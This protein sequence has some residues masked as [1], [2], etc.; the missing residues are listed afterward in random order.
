[1]FIVLD[2]Y[3]KCSQV[4]ETYPSEY[5]LEA[6]LLIDFQNQGYEFLP[7]LKTPAAMLQRTRAITSL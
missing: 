2:K 4:K 6:D 7:E 3:T 1:M 5:T